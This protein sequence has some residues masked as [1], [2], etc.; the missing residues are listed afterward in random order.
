MASPS[1][2]G[3]RGPGPPARIGIRVSPAP[4]DDPAAA[5]NQVL[6]EVIDAILD[7]RQAHRRVPETQTLHAELDQ[8]FAD[9][10]TWA[11]LLADQDQALGVSPLASMPSA[12]GRTPPNPWHGPASNEEVRR[13]V[14]EHLD[15]LG[16]HLSA[17]L[18]EQH[19]DK[20]RAVLTEVE[21]GILAHGRSLSDL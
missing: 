16:R 21:R 4:R 10:R 5:L 2:P 3:V 6:S 9:L 14:G 13:I 1:S 20:V 19:D 11:R 12:A 15:R 7:V 18:A 17:A 8:L